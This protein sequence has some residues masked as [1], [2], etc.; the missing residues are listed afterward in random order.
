MQRSALH[1][2]SAVLIFV[3][4]SHE[5]RA[6]ATDPVF[7]NSFESGL[8]AFG[9][10]LSMI[11]LG[12]DRPTVGASLQVRLSA[13]AVAPTFVPVTSTDPSVLTITDGG[14]IVDTGQT[15]AA[16]R[17]TGVVMSTTP[18]TVWAT[19]GNTVGA[20]V[21]SYIPEGGTCRTGDSSDVLN[22]TRQCVGY[23]TN[24]QGATTWDDTFA[25]LF[26]GEWPGSASQA[27]QPFTVT[28][29][30][31]QYGA[32][33][34]STGTVEAGIRI[35]PNTD[36]GKAGLASISTEAQGPG[37]FFDGLC[38]GSTLT[39]SSKPG[40]TATCKLSANSTYYLNLSMADYFPPHLTD[41][42]TDTCTIAW[43]LDQ[44]DD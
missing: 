18:V 33:R 42:P 7:A 43:T 15:N 23:A 41:C 5:S 3:M 25:Q 26:W 34:L 17:V 16:V 29:N 14:V 40:T 31:T 11:S 36:V 13:P 10:P 24:F 19:L 1:A 22:F 30:A 39:I 8:I 44:F 35:T 4:F 32:F 6:Q 12:A 2:A 20:A 38:V 28:V 9:P 27:G 37:Y 21:L